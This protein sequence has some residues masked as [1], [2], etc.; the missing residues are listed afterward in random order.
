MGVGDSQRW[1]SHRLEGPGLDRRVDPGDSGC[2]G[3]LL[4]HSTSLLVPTLAPR[5]P[6][7]RP[8]LRPGVPDYTDT[9]VRCRGRV[10]ERRGGDDKTRDGTREVNVGP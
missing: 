9:P 7:H 3:G 8:A 1:D 4:L 2:F 10:W 6:R 5:R